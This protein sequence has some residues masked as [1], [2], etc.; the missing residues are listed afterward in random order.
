MKRA[1]QTFALFF[2]C[3]TAAIVGCA[4][5]NP[6][7]D[8]SRNQVTLPVAV[9]ARAITDG[10]RG[11]LVAI[12]FI[13]HECPISNAMAPDLIALA[14]SC[15]ARGVA[16]HLVHASAWVDD[17]TIAKHSADFD[18]AGAMIVET[19]RTHALV[20]ATGATIT[21]EAVLLRLDGNG[22]FDRLYLG[23]VN[24]LYAAIGRRR[25]QATT[26]D[27]SDAIDAALT[28]RPIAL[29][30]AKAVGCFIE[31]LSPSSR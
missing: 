24:D 25:A 12:V 22:G 7:P 13:S 23:R 20:I 8:A 17:A 14:Q 30:A 10:A 9:D 27:F 15:R 3:V 6:S 11:T 26:N 21:P 16:F 1:R 2:A 29:N 18:L 4:A 5:S 28:G 19:D 31:P